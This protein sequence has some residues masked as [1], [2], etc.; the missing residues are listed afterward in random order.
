MQ[1]RV[2]QGSPLPRAWVPRASARRCAVGSAGEHR[3][4]KLGGSGEGWAP[5]GKLRATDQGRRG[6]P[7]LQT[8]DLGLHLCHP[9]SLAE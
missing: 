8:L 6:W 9:S 5:T 3:W 7:H 1:P 4:A 2:T